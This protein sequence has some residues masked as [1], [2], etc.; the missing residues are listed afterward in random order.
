MSNGSLP[1]QYF[2]VLFCIPR[3]SVSNI[4]TR[5]LKLVPNDSS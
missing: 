2:P 3:T 5:N 1:N 4:G